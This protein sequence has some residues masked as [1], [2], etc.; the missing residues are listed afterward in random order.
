M[1]DFRDELIKNFVYYTTFDTMSNPGLLG[2]KRPTTEGQTVLLEELVREL[3]ELGIEASLDPASVA[4]GFIKGNTPGEAK[5]FMAHVDTADDVMGDGVKAIVHDYEGGDIS[6]PS[7]IVLKEEDNP[8]LKKYKGSKIIT[9]DGTTLLGSDDK[10]GIAIIMSA[11][12]YLVEHPE[13]KHPDIE[14]YFTPDEETGSGMYAFPYERVKAACCYTVDGSAEGKIETECFNA[15]TLSVTVSGVSIHL[16]S[17]R[18]VMVNALTI[19]S[20]IAST[21]PQAESPE[22]TDGR[23]GYYCAQNIK[24]TATE[25]GMQIFIRDH[26]E[27]AFKFRIEAVKKLVDAIAF[28]YKG[29]A[30]VDVHISYYNMANGNKKGGEY[31]DARFKACESLG[32]D[33]SREI[34]RGGTDGARIADKLKIS[35]PNIFTGGHNLHSL[36][37]WLSVEAMNKSA[38]LV[39]ALMESR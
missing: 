3:K 17:A 34:I 10:A 21:L 9:S 2:K 11:A 13:I 38:N 20:Q 12:R 31:V 15:A 26:D 18:G 32:I 25:A 24:G 39:L 35:S 36:S 1:K 33:S 5:A 7:G 22:A 27:D 37:E 4:C 8:G 14:I 19:L 16:G 6:L 30:C 28:I 23:Y 29:K